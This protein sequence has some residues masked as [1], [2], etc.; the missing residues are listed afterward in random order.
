MN[1]SLQININTIRIADVD[2][3]SAVAIGYN[4]FGDWRITGKE[5]NGFGRLNGD[6]GTL[7]DDCFSLHD[8][9][10]VDMAWLEQEGGEANHPVTT[11]GEVSPGDGGIPG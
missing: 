8:P 1:V 6:S 5:N 4:F 7:S 10:F 3:G 2:T 11:P 9:D